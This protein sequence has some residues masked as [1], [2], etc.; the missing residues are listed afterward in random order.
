MKNV[1][2]AL[3]FMLV[4]T[5]AFANS[6]VKTSTATFNEDLGSCHI[7]IVNNQTGET[8]VDITLPANSAEA[9][10]AMLEATLDDLNKR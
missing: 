1:F 6:N 9:C 7:V 2:L 3:A 4:G 8:V 10:E 5:F